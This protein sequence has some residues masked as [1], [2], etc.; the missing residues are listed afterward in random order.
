[1][2]Q[3]LS[4][5]CIGTGAIGTY[6]GGSLAL[7][8]HRVTFID[9]PEVVATLQISGLTLEIAGRTWKV[10]NPVFSS[11][12]ESAFENKNYDVCIFALKSYDTDSAISLMLPFQEKI[13]PVIC[14][15]NGVDN[16]LKLIK[17]FGEDRVI[18]GTVTSSVG[19]KGNGWIV[20][21]KLRGVGISA[22]HSLSLRLVDEMN[23]SGLS[24]KIFPNAASMKWSKMLTNLL[25]NASSAILDMTP[26]QIL[27]DPALFQLEVT[28]L[29]EALSVMKKQEI[30]VTDLP[31]TPV[32][33][34]AF[35][36]ESL[37]HSISK[38]AL[39]R[40]VGRGRGAKMPS[41]HIDLYSDRGRSEVGFL[42]GAVVRSGEIYG[43]PTPI[44]GILCQVLQD[45]TDKKIPISTFRLQPGKLLELS[46]S[47]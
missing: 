38:I 9:R 13:P 2:D 28:Q 26:S 40:A 29:R 33:L 34:L 37:P 12:L 14:L 8:G 44:N 7:Q 5:L 46:K 41:F 21:E 16:E 24:A 6:I 47:Q 1:M 15:Q 31:G 27:A 39:A 30:L 32:R 17:Q 19:K 10:E 11:S 36:V 4:I 23:T 3:N 42:N 20:L 43:I 18:P 45:L 25:A 22:G 35:A